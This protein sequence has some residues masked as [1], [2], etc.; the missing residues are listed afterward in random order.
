MSA[1]HWVLSGCLWLVLG[2]CIAAV[3]AGASTRP[4]D[5]ESAVVI[6]LGFPLVLLVL[7]LVLLAR[8][9]SRRPVK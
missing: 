1:E 5:R 7:A 9:V 4:M 3:L 6:V 2:M 8:R